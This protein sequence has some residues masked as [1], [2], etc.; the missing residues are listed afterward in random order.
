MTYFIDDSSS[1]AEFSSHQTMVTK[2][3]LQVI[4]VRMIKFA[5]QTVDI[6]RCIAATVKKKQFTMSTQTNGPVA[7][8]FTY[9]FDINNVTNSGGT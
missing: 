7:L 2:L 4:V 5:E 9:T 8:S 1:T 3:N 6:R